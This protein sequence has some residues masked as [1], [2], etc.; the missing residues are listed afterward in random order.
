MEKVKKLLLELGFNMDSLGT[1]Y[2]LD[3]FDY[4]QKHPLNTPFKEV[5]ASVSSNLGI[6][7]YCLES[8][9]RR[10]MDT[11]QDS[12]QKMFNY[13]GKITTKTFLILVLYI[14]R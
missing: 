2:W 1:I 8:Q 14:V 7:K 4:C 9:L 3:V 5:L 6:T 10:A 12:I 11:A 13:K